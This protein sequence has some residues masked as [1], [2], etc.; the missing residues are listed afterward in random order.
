LNKG[1]VHGNWMVYAHEKSDHSRVKKERLIGTICGRA[2]K[3]CI[4]HV[5]R[6][7][8]AIFTRF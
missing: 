8:I 6:L 4:V 7:G 3:K 5:K 1:F 2:R